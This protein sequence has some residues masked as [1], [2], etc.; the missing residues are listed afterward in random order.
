MCWDTAL[1][2]VQKLNCP[3][4]PRMSLFKQAHAGIQVT[5][6]W[7][8]G[9]RW[10]KG[11][12]IFTVLR[13]IF[14]RVGECKY[15]SHV[16]MKREL[17]PLCSFCHWP[18]V[19]RR[20]RREVMTAWSEASRV[21]QP[22]LA[23]W[24]QLCALTV[25][26]ILGFLQDRWRDD[27]KRELLSIS[28][29]HSSSLKEVQVISEAV[30]WLRGVGRPSPRDSPQK[31]CNC[32]IKVWGILRISDGLWWVNMMQWLNSH[33]IKELSSDAPAEL[34]TAFSL[35]LLRYRHLAAK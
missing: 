23:G 15:F 3:P 20:T 34:K 35:L 14:L 31:E 11:N 27:E 1:P 29:S 22:Q 12:I 16:S 6:L 5:N 28:Q 32:K 19:K 24:D 17:Q 10:D 33:E 21:T 8:T 13:I 25:I 30:S 26:G 9:T 18:S 4:S 2:S 7:V